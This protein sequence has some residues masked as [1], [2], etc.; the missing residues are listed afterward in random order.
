MYLEHS[1][2][3]VRE[4]I[5]N[6]TGSQKAHGLAATERPCLGKTL[7]REEGGF[8]I[9]ERQDLTYIY[10]D[11]SVYCAGNRVEAKGSSKPTKDIY[12]L[13]GVVSFVFGLRCYIKGGQG[14]KSSQN[15]LHIFQ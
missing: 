4:G 5:R 15:E 9:K 2:W 12:C 13:V 10:V 7:G 1:G 6:I 8:S 11:S 14:W 3:E